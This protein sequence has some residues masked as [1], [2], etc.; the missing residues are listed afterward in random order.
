MSTNHLP[1]IMRSTMFCQVFALTSKCKSWTGTGGLV[2][3]D[4]VGFTV[5]ALDCDFI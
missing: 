1:D 3:I 5:A 4:R 2:P